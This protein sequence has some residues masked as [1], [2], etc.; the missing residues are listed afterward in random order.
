MTASRAERLFWLTL[1]GRVVLWTLLPSLVASSAP[2]DVIE[3]LAWGQAWQWGYWKHPPL[4]AWILAATSAIFGVRLWPLFLAGQLAVAACL[5]AVWR[6]GRELVGAPAALLSVLVLDGIYYYNIAGTK[7]NP[8]LLQL[9]FWA[10][11]IL[12]LH[13]ALVR[14]RTL[15]WALLGLAVGLALLA[16]YSAGALLLASAIVLGA[17]AEGRRSLRRP[18]PWL[19][20]GVAVLVLA[21]HVSWLVSH[22]FPSVAYARDRLIRVHGFR[23]RVEVPLLFTAGQLLALLPAGLLVRAIGWCAGGWPRHEGFPRRFLLAVALGPFLLT[24]GAGILFGRNLVGGSREAWG[25]PFWSFA[26][27][28]LAL[29]Q[30][31]PDTPRLRRFAWAWAAV[32]LL[33]ATAYLA[34][35]LLLP[36]ITQAGRRES[37]PGKA[38][39]QF[40]QQAWRR[41]VASPLAFVGG[42]VW[43]AG[44]V[45]FFHPEHPP[46]F[47]DLD[48]GKSPW[49]DEAEL[50]RCGA[51]VLWD[52]QDAQ[53]ADYRRLL[54]ARFPRH[55][56]Q[57]IQAFA[58][59]TPARPRPFW[60]GFAILPPGRT[61]APARV[62]VSW[63]DNTKTQTIAGTFKP[64][65]TR[66]LEV[67]VGGLRK[68]L[69]LDWD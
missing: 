33:A 18:G 42:D 66:R 28:L 48:R 60:L 56:L 29:G 57:P 38:L 54:L 13:R 27:L 50:L 34:S 49:I 44:N 39:A 3:G 26:P 19:A 4:A 20:A 12:F 17:T 65:A 9:P 35:I 63:E 45:S 64:G 7:L 11:S 31:A 55:E 52:A 58:F 32:V 51:V 22:G 59:H 2:L 8:D 15:Y 6:L 67:R 43:L 53:A 68:S 62:Q 14:D 37:F 69:S 16:K 46:V 1:G 21:P 23:D 36:R 25:T 10:V 61:S 30:E 5:Y 24:L 47:I 40:V 41:R